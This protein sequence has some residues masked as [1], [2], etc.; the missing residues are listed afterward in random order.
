MGAVRLSCMINLILAG[1]AFL[2]QAM[3]YSGIPAAMAAW[4]GAQGFSPFMIIACLTLI[5]LILGCFIDGISMIVLTVS[6]VL[7][8]IQHR[9]RPGVVRHLHRAGG[10]TG[11]DHAAG[12]LQPVRAAGPDARA[13][14]EVAKNTLPFFFLM[15]VGVALVTVFPPIVTWL[16]AQMRG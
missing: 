5:Y 9:L 1:A 13:I 16:P 2:T 3:A 6:V 15:L 7:P 11:A 14:V 12:R 8:I 10:G 4:V